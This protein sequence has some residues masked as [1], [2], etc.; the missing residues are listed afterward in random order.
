MTDTRIRVWDPLVR[1]FHWSLVVTFTVAYFT[2]D[3]DNLVHIWSGYAVIGLVIFRILWG[4]IGSRHARF[5]DF[6]ASPARVLDYLKS[7]AARQP[8]RYLGHNP[9]G[10]WMIVLLLIAILLTSISGIKVYGLEGHGPLASSGSEMVLIS[11]A[12][13]DEDEH[14]EHEEEHGED[15]HEGHEDGAEEFW[16]EIH[17]FLSN[18]TVFLIALHI[19]GVLVSSALH[20]ENLVRAMITGYKQGGRE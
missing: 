13:A 5:S 10:G 8:E 6:L 18:F 9:A 15:G 16:E 4:F 1:L 19:A 7:L 3:E 2:G 20:R 17:E 11:T 12:Q 14:E